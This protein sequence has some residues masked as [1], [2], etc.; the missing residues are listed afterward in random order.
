LKLRIDQHTRERAEERGTN[1][2][3]IQEVLETGIPFQ[4]GKRRLGKA[5]IFAFN[6]H[7]HGRFYEQKR[8]EVIYTPE[9]DTFVTVTVYVYYGKWEGAR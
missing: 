2:E 9:H 6:R 4:T 7:R 8:V 5:K 1:A 3:E